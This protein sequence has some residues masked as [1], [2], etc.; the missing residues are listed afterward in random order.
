MSEVERRLAEA[1][2]ELPPPPR[3]VGRFVGAVATGSLLFLSGAGPD[4]DG[5]AVV[6]GKLG[7]DLTVDQ[8]RDAAQLTALNLLA[9]AKGELGD[10]DRVTRVVKLLCFVNSGEDFHRQPEVANAASDLLIEA[11]GDRGRHARSSI[12]VYELPAG[13]PVELEAVFEFA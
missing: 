11:F 6:V 8:G 7:R 9:V 10:L 5:R 3:P 2:L 12:G 4:R 13:I 1:G